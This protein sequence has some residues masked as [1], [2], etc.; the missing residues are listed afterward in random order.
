MTHVL[1][2]T[3][4]SAANMNEFTFVMFSVRDSAGKKLV[5]LS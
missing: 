3:H 1:G 5:E 2:G 4:T